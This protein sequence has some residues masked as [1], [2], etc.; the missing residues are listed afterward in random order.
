MTG[1]A[2]SPPL[3]RR[4]SDRTH[5]LAQR[6]LS[7]EHGRALVAADFALDETETQGLSP[8]MH[9]AKALRLVAERAPIRILP[10]ERIVGSATLR[11]AVGGFLR[12]P[13]AKF[14]AVDHVTLGLDRVLEIG[15]SGLR[16]EAEERLAHGDLDAHGSDLLHAMLAC[17][18][19]AGV[20]HRRHLDLLT[21]LASESREEERENYGRLSETLRRVPEHPPASFPEAVQS[22][23]FMF[24]FLRLCGTW[25]GIGRIDRMLGPYLRRDLARGAITLDDARELLAHFWIKG[26][27]WTGAHNFDGTGDAQFYQNIVLGGVDADGADGVNDV[28]YLVLDVVEELRI[29]DFPIAVRI[30]ARTPERLLRRIAEVQ[31]LGGGIV[32]VYN[33]DVVIEGMVR[34]GYSL[35]EARRF[36]NDG[37]WEAQVPGKTRFGYF[38][39]DMMGV[40]QRVLGL[41]ANAPAPAPAYAA[42]DDL[43]AAFRDELARFLTEFH[44]RADRF[45]EPGAPTP[46]VS[47]FIEDCIERGR[48]YLEG[49]ARYNVLSPHAGGMAD[50]ANS[51]LAIRELVFDEGGMTLPE[52]V[53]VLR[54][55]WEGEEGL[56]Q[57]IRNRFAYYGNDN[58]EADAMV[59]RVF[60]DYTD[61]VWAVRE[62]NGVLRP[63]GISTF[64]REIGW[65]REGNWGYGP[66]AAAPHGYRRGDYLA[67]N[68]SPT[69]G[70]DRDGPTAVIN[71]YCKMDFTRTPNGATLELKLHPSCV[72]GEAG[73]DA[74]VALLRAF[75]RQGGW[76]LQ[77]DVV[78]SAVLRDAQLHPDKYPNLAVRVSG[79]SARFATLSKE[80]QDMVINRTQQLVV[81]IV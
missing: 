33:E 69:P 23:W 72:E 61:L 20:W 63:A 1:R 9:Y 34:F 67:T 58:D 79:W 46:L 39:F 10:G 14:H 8:N 21:G 50:A 2:F 18:D 66:R 25:S 42:F 59:R 74:L 48:G 15:Y 73:I 6:G 78:D 37:C 53:E 81:E 11:E 19:A 60:N 40:L 4:L 45:R 47:L 49:G 24:A 5:D 31:R 44:A 13:V 56:R 43:Y 70:S 17:L 27:E 28:T 38:P 77:I 32:A 68:F 80:W 35:P 75:V 64:A 51:L 65:R 52:F 54:T 26:T 62:R 36:A 76:F 41:D 12:T 22:L 30:N 55:D 16:R 3:P 29:S 71:S 57:R 7:G